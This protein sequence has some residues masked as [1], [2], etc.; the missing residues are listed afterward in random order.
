MREAVNVR[1]GIFTD[2]VLLLAGVLWI[3]LEGAPSWP[4][5]VCAGAGFVLTIRAGH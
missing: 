1:G 3:G 5:W 4:G 2:A